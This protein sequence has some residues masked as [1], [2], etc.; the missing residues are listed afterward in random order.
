MAYQGLADR[1]KELEDENRG[2]R[3]GDTP[4]TSPPAEQTAFIEIQPLP[5]IKPPDSKLATKINFGNPTTTDY[6]IEKEYKNYYGGGTQLTGPLATGAFSGLETFPP[7]NE[8]NIKVRKVDLN[9]LGTAGKLGIGSLTLESLYLTTHKNN[10]DRQP[11]P[12]GR[13]DENGNP[14]FIN[15]VRPGMGNLNGLDIKGYSTDKISYRGSDRGKE[16]YFIPEIGSTEQFYGKETHTSR[17]VKFYKSKAGG[18]TLLK[19]N[20]LAFAFALDKINLSNIKL[21]AL[22]GGTLT[23]GLNALIGLQFRRGHDS[24]FYNVFAQQLDL[25]YQNRE[26]IAAAGQSITIGQI[27]D[28]GN[29]LGSLRRPFAIEYSARKRVG[30]P[31][32]DLGDRPWNLRPL[33]KLNPDKI[34]PKYKGLKK[35]TTKLRDIGLKEMDR[36]GNIPTFKPSPF[37]DLSGGPGNHNDGSVFAGLFNK[38]FRGYDDKIADSEVLAPKFAETDFFSEGSDSPL[39]NTIGQINNGDFYVRFKDLRDGNFIYFRGYVTGITENLSPSW[40]ST[41]FIGR[42]EPVYSYQRAERDISF[43]LAVYPQD[44]QQ[45]LAMYRKID[46]L[47]SLVYPSYGPVQTN[48]SVRGKEGP[49]TEMYMAHIGSKQIGQFG[50]IKSLSYTVNESGDWD[51]ISAVPRVFNIAIS[52]QIVSKQSPRLGSSFYGY[53]D[54]AYNTLQKEGFKTDEFGAGI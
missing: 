19:E 16:P 5:V 10:P 12:T 7:Y 43:N 30:L 37:F 39:E 3:P 11:I 54:D 45:Q 26:I 9:D 32:G 25:D 41:N 40:T 13:N 14:I 4:P 27:S 8:D 49:F 18:Q 34:N 38:K 44:G 51:A 35:F 6:S 48:S 33:A 2:R 46:R 17:L 22:G 20:L 53:Q 24:L 42:S 36:I 15:T 47:T 50:Y 29:V 28:I 21:P 23:S 52:Y 31:F 1:F